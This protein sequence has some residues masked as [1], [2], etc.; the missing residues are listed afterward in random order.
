MRRGVWPGG[1]HLTIAALVAICMQTPSASAQ[2]PTQ[3]VLVLERA[4]PTFPPAMRARIES[5]MQRSMAERPQLA[6]EWSDMPLDDV[7]M[8][9]GCNASE[10]ACRQGIAGTVDAQWLLVREFVVSAA[11]VSE[12]RLS[13]HRPKDADAIR[14]A[15]SIVT[16]EGPTAPE[17][18]VPALMAQLYPKVGQVAPAVTSTPTP[19]PAEPSGS[20]APAQAADESASEASA[21]SASS[22]Y[23]DG[24]SR[25]NR[26]LRA[27]G[28]ALAV[29]G[30][31]LVAAGAT[32][33]GIARSD[34]DDY[35]SASIRS[36]ADVDRAR[37][38]LDRAQERSRRANAL[39]I[40]G[41]IV[42]AAGVSALLVGLF[43]TSPDQE[44]RVT[45]SLSPQ[46]RGAAVTLAGT[47]DGI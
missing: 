32:L 19:K 11:G 42:T 9:A 38:L 1:L 20:E 16:E 33:G 2:T 29:V 46:H 37:D 7:A 12:L 27:S 22:E 21:A 24:P 17:Q 40:S 6:F 26:I 8:A 5:A 35:A 45:W 13:A 18:A 15:Q 34:H 43:R 4:A 30:C 31:S 28:W 14:R 25:S 10:D 23:S 47:W 44:Q 36:E 3:R 41:G 39:L